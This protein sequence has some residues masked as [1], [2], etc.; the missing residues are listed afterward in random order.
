MPVSG[1]VWG[2]P[3]RNFHFEFFKF[4]LREFQRQDIGPWRL[5][6]FWLDV[7]KR[8]P[9][10]ECSTHVWSLLRG[11]PL[12]IFDF[13]L[14][15][16]ELGRRFW[17]HASV[18]DIWTSSLKAKPYT[19]VI[20]PCVNPSEGESLAFFYFASCNLELSGFWQQ[21]IDLG[22][23]GWSDLSNPK[24]FYPEWLNPALVCGECLGK[25]RG[26]MGNAI[27]L[28]WLWHPYV[29]GWVEKTIVLLD[30]WLDSWQFNSVTQRA[31]S[32]RSICAT[33]LPW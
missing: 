27:T 6:L 25:G 2:N 24:R 18:L 31:G 9:D 3:L 12:Q 15:K 13:A 30:I 19:Q 5:W 10:S 20:C 4:E 33:G 17:W 1:P 22:S 32:T 7:L 8:S 14:F 21:D 23:C 29:I 26:W 28:C 11:N 16:L